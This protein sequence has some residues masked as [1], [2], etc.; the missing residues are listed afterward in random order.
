MFSPELAEYVLSLTF[1]KASI[2]RYLK[3][4]AKAQE[5]TLTA[6]EEAE[7]DDY[8]SANTFLAVLKS[9]AR[10]SLNKAR[11]RA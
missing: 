8:L 2:K 4:S 6:A 10:N 1:P 7:L 3:L 11:S 5:G 9:K